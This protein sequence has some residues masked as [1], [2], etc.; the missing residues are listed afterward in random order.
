M[1][2][3]P[4]SLWEPPDLHCCDFPGVISLMQTQHLFSRSSFFH[5]S[6]YT[7]HQFHKVCKCQENTNLFS[8]GS[9]LGW[10][11]AP[12]SGNL[13]KLI[14]YSSFLSQIGEISKRKVT[15][16]QIHKK[17][18]VSIVSGVDYVLIHCAWCIFEQEPRSCIRGVKA[19][20]EPQNAAL[21]L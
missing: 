9:F 2:F 4:Q 5:S 21:V 18:I 7:L 11:R 17:T 6:Y 19:S 8:S 20:H 10:C 3:S 16:L 1:F 15:V 14:G 12:W 13:T